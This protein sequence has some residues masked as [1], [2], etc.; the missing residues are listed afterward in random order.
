MAGAAIAAGS[1]ILGG[2]L[3][4]KGAEKAA[5]AAAQAQLQAAQL[6]IN[7]ESR[8]FN[9]TQ[10]NLQPW[11]QAGGQALGGQQDLLGL[12]GNGPQ[13]TSIAD[14]QNSPLYQSLMRNG[15]NTILANGSATGGLRGGNMQNSLANFGADTLTSVIQQQL[16]NLGGLS[17]T[18]QTTGTQLG[19]LGQNNANA[20]SNLYGQQGAA[21]A[22]G[23]TSAAGTNA[24][25]TNTLFS[26]VGS[27]F[28]GS[29]P[30]SGLFSGGSSFSLPSSFGGGSP[31]SDY[32]YNSDHSFG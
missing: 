22:G 27:L 6:G 15:Q 17:G 3:G 12:N 20:I 9:T 25:T 11:L 5:K 8:E 1:S 26:S 24:N 4:G 2:V 21:T 16:A 14:L 32:S 18:G 19:Q 7:E 13:A 31:I 10:Q 30:L 29:G 28:G 23:I